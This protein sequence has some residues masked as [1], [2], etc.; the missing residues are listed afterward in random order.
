[1]TSGAR[2]LAGAWAL[3]CAL[4]L[5]AP[6]A[7]A[8][9]TPELAVRIPDA[10]PGC[11]TPDLATC[12]D[13]DFLDS[14]CGLYELTHEATC[15]ALWYAAM[16]GASSDAELGPVPAEIA[17]DGIAEVIAAPQ[18]PIPP[19]AFHTPDVF[20]FGSQ[21]AASSYATN[22]T[23]A[24]DQVGQWQDNG[25]RV[26]S[27]RELVWETYYATNIYQHA[28]RF[29]PTDYRYQVDTAF[30]PAGNDASIGTLHANSSV[31]YGFDGTPFGT[32][33]TGAEVPKNAFFDIP[34]HPTLRRRPSP[35]GAPSLMLSL[36][37]HS[38]GAKLLLAVLANVEDRT[39]P[40][41]WT[42]Q[43]T[44]DEALSV[45]GNPMPPNGWLQLAPPP[46]DPD[47]FL[48]LEL[49]VT[50]DEENPIRRR[51]DRELNELDH[52]QRRLRRTLRDWAR[53]DVE[54]AGSGWTP[55]D[56]LP[57]AEEEPDDGQGGPG[58]L[59]F[60][61]VNVP[62][63]TPGGLVL[64]LAPPEPPNLAPMLDLQAPP[65]PPAETMARRRVLSEIVGLLVEGAE[66]GCI[67]EGMT[68]CDYSPAAF[69]RRVRNDFVDE[70][71]ALL[72]QCDDFVGGQFSNILNLDIPFVDDPEY[73]LLNC[74]VHTGPTIT[75]AGYRAL[76]DRVAECRLLKAE[77]DRQVALAEARARVLAVE[78][79][80]D[81]SSGE[82]REPGRR[83]ERHEHIGDPDSFGMGYDFEFGFGADFDGGI[84]QV[85]IDAG[86]YFEAFAEA[87]GNRRNLIDAEA[88]FDT[89]ERRLDLSLEIA[90][91]N[92]FTPVHFD[93]EPLE[94][95]SFNP[96]DTAATEP[97]RIP[98]IQAYFTVVF[99][100]VKIEMGISGQ[101]GLDYGLRTT[102]QPPNNEECPYIF[103][104]GLVEPWIGIDAY[105]SA[106]VDLFVIGGGIRGALNLITG[107]LPFSA[108][109][110]IGVGEREPPLTVDANP[111]LALAPELTLNVDMN[112]DLELSTLSGGLYLYGYIGP[113]PFCLSGE[114]RIA[115]WPG[116]EWSEP[117]IAQTY[118]VNLGDLGVA[119]FGE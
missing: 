11:G 43:R 10:L 118:A 86:G 34:D 114:V 9:R 103:V 27:C 105:A 17:A 16:D 36:Y 60:P 91:K 90:G 66:A 97:K 89:V 2:R 77:Y 65:L 47:A 80:V 116:I 42:N 29:R 111:V 106:G 33:F 44:L 115:G 45:E 108:G 85:D 3:A 26:T 84:C 107:S 40:D 32:L 23:L 62:P 19:N 109:L 69:A 31:L 83:R 100:P 75:A 4:A 96:T 119:L 93:W 6:D 35:E 98:L 56:L 88:R 67:A 1:M 22:D 7:R 18:P 72:D 71:D 117:I 59:A 64:A 99:V 54:Y 92:L 49:G 58:F 63:P 50:P 104:G 37:N 82:I 25:T 28:I 113:C 94:A 12:N 70:Q 8:Q 52:L 78:E 30:G 68:P 76:V 20:S 48:A 74:T 81:P 95:L 55:A 102:L 13:P 5:G 15:A 24:F 41:T 110:R 14:D 61:E 51:F 112:L 53:L 46:N 73:P 21:I 87:L 57:P 39:H 101:V 38:F 79:L